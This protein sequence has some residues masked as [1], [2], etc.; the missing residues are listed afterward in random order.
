MIN[1]DSPALIATLLI[2]LFLQLHLILSML[3]LKELAK[4]IIR[5]LIAAFALAFAYYFWKSEIGILAI[6]A[7]FLGGGLA[8]LS[9]GNLLLTILY[10]ISGIDR[11]F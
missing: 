2:I 1:W 3:Q 9:F 8:L 6:F 5:C 11:K 4:S 10:R 7:L